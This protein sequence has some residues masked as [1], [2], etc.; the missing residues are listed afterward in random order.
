MSFPD[1]LHS[2]LDRISATA[3]AGFDMLN[4]MS[5]SALVIFA[6]GLAA[7][8]VGVGCLIYGLRGEWRRWARIHVAYWRRKD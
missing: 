2:A 3:V 6:I 8:V 4:R 5:D 7:A 1:T